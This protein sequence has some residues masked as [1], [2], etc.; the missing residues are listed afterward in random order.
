MSTMNDSARPGCAKA[1]AVFVVAVAAA[2]VVAMVVTTFIMNAKCVV[3]KLGQ[4]FVCKLFLMG[5]VI[6]NLTG[7]LHLGQPTHL[8]C[9]A[10]PFVMHIALTFASR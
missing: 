8:G 2:A 9:I 3:V 5:C 1:I 6:L 4:P 7:P 10:R